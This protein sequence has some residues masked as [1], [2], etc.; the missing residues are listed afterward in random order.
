MHDPDRA[1]H[2]VGRGDRQIRGTQEFMACASQGNA[3]SMLSHSTF[4]FG[5]IC[6]GTRIAD[7]RALGMAFVFFQTQ[8]IESFESFRLNR[9]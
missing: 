8:A 4:V 1:P 7:T 5:L 3:T 2:A 6:H 9:F